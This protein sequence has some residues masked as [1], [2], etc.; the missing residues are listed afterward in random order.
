MSG[1][2]HLFFI[3]HHGVWPIALQEHQVARSLATQG[4]E[5]VALTCDGALFPLCLVMDSQAIKPEE[6]GKKQKACEVCQRKRNHAIHH[7]GFREITLDSLITKSDE[8]EIAL[9]LRGLDPTHVTE[10]TFRGFPAGRKSLFD[11]LIQYKKID[12]DFNPEEFAHYFGHLHSSLKTIVAV[13]NLL[14]K[15]RFDSVFVYSSHASAAQCLAGVAEKRKLPVWNIHSGLAVSKR[16]ESLMIGSEGNKTIRL[17]YKEK[18]PDFREIPATLSEIKLCAAEVISTIRSA[19]VYGYSPATRPGH[20]LNVRER[21]GVRPDQKLISVTM[22][23]YDEMFSSETLGHTKFGSKHLFATQIEWIEFLLHHAR[24][25]PDLFFL[26]RVHPREFPNKRESVL[27]YHARMLQKQFQSLPGNAAINWPSDKISIFDVAKF[28][29]LF[30]NAWSSAGIDMS[31]LG[32]PVLSYSNEILFYP[33]DL[34]YTGSSHEEYTCAIDQALTDG[35]SERK[36]R[37]TFRWLS[38]LWIRAHFHLAGEPWSQRLQ[39]YRLMRG[40]SRVYAK[41]TG[42]PLLEQLDLSSLPELVPADL[43]SLRKMVASNSTSKADVIDPI[44][45]ELRTTQSES[46]ALRNAVRQLFTAMYGEGFVPT[47]E[48][49]AMRLWSAFR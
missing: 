11:T 9:A 26:I 6:N 35:W 20:E 16:F 8:L 28:T 10:F 18:W 2:K 43:A 33:P 29:D 24:T 46:E 3:P 41:V 40:L 31:L 47:E 39:T 30:L 13:E 22:S 45:D 38:F 12:L 27:S 21:F 42:M 7:S 17:R 5:I 32:I 1:L 19:S 14:D 34:N 15:E 36:I 48:G 44:D 49:L 23:S 4:D 37:Y 25:R